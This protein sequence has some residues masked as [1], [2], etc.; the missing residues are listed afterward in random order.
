MPSFGPQFPKLLEILIDVIE[1]SNFVIL[2]FFTDFFKALSTYNY[3]DSAKK[4]MMN[5]KTTTPSAF[6]VTP[7]RFVTERLKTSSVKAQD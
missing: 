3:K 6:P 7:H 2:L 5:K 1:L 4:Y